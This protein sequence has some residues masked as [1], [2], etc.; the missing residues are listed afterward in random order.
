MVCVQCLT[1][2]QSVSIEK[3]MDSFCMQKTDFP[4]VC[5]IIDDASTDGEPAVLQAYLKKNFDLDDR[6][7]ARHEETQDYILLF[8]Q[9]KTNTNCFFGVLL[10]KY[11]HFKIRK[12]KV[13][14]YSPWTTSRYMAFCEG[15]DYWTDTT[16]LQIQADALNSHPECSLCG[17]GFVKRFSDGSPDED[18]TIYG[19]DSNVRI[20]DIYQWDRLNIVHTLTLMC[21]TEGFLNYVGKIS[22][23][24][25]SK[26]TYLFY[27]LFKN[28]KCVYI[29]QPT[30]VY[31][32]NNLGIWSS[33][34]HEQQIESAFYSYRELYLMNGRDSVIYMHYF[35]YLL[36]YVGCKTRHFS[37]FKLLKEGLRETRDSRDRKSFIKTY[38][39]Y[40]RENGAW[41]VINRLRVRLAIGSRLKRIVGRG[42]NR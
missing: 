28:G 36:K 18:K 13:A 10:L 22:K 30:G 14:Y 27:H 21:R 20:Y 7:L 26:D 33:M 23:Y 39:A 2:N 1:Y 35:P 16:K 5:V 4:F 34:T 38:I 19:N 3:A 15:D 29:P 32:V 40:R 11:N 25:Y 8:A 17:T 41:G 6:A 42:N 12:D 37:D 24:K 31:N 9:H